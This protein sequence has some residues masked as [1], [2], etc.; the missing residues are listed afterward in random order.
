MIVRYRMYLESRGLAANTINQQLAATSL[1]AGASK[2]RFTSGVWRNTLAE[3]VPLGQ[4][5]ALLIASILG[6]DHPCCTAT[7]YTP[8]GT[9][10]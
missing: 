10:S 2:T 5:L 8:L 3:V 9:A 4:L 6:A 7:Y 1:A